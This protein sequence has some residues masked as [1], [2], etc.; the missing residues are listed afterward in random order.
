MT[1]TTHVLI[2]WLLHLLQPKTFLP[3]RHQWSPEGPRAPQGRVPHRGKGPTGSRR[4]STRTCS[5]CSA[6][7]GWT[8]SPA[9]GEGAALGCS[10]TSV[11]CFRHHFWPQSS[12]LSLPLSSKPPPHPTNPC[13]ASTSYPLFHNWPQPPFLRLPWLILKD[14]ISLVRQ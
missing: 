3:E 8:Q 9:T 13:T 2:S 7:S 11:A 10:S 6:R 4:P 1:R 5:T 12:S 14:L